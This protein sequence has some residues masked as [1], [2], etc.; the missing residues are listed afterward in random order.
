MS[1]TGSGVGAEFSK[2]SAE[3]CFWG[4]GVQIDRNRYSVRFG[5]GYRGVAEGRD[6][7]REI[8]LPSGMPGT[9]LLL[10]CVNGRRFGGHCFFIANAGDRF[11][12]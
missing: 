11:S 3:N 6:L 9:L 8:G 1:G 10:S 2:I 5:I 7:S 4:K 12:G